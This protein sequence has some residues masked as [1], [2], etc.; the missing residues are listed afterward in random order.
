MPSTDPPSKI[1]PKLIGIAG[2]SASCKTT[3]ARALASRLGPSCIVIGEDDYY[4]CSTSIRNFDATTHNFDEPA[5]KDDELLCAHLALARAGQTFEKPLYDLKTHTRMKQTERIAPA[6]FMIVEGLHVLATPA[7]C[8][9]FDLKIYTEAEEA[10][11][12]GRRMIR[13][14]NERARTPQSVLT[15]FFT[16]VRPMHELH[17]APQR[18]YADLVLVSTFEGGYPETDENVEKVLRALGL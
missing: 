9:S 16:N 13:D 3:I 2:G 8:A 17:V 6:D 10:L 18:K 7:L 5:A 11:R 12:L 15:Q 1:K 14:V 4:R